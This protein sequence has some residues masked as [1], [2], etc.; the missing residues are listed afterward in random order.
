M[1]P[2]AGHDPMPPRERHRHAA[3][4]PTEALPSRRGKQSLPFMI[5]LIL[6]R[7]SPCTRGPPPGRTP[8]SVG[9]TPRSVGYCFARF[10]Q[11]V[12]PS[13]ADSINGVS[14]PARRTRATRPRPWPKRLPSKTAAP[15]INRA[16]VTPSID[17]CCV[18]LTQRATSSPTCQA[19]RHRRPRLPFQEARRRSPRW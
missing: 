19:S 8:R 9:R 16:F 4:I 3:P 12:S 6:S 15:G 14:N 10:A 5:G 2:T 11:P 17:R 7:C 13:P 18:F 1:S